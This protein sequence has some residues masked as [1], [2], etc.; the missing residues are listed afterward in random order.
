[1]LECQQKYDLFRTSIDSGQPSKE[2]QELFE[3][4]QW[5]VWYL[6]KAIER[7]DDVMQI[8]GP[9][10]YKMVK[11]F[12]ALEGSALELFPED[13]KDLAPVLES[14]LGDLAHVLGSP[15]EID[16]KKRELQPAFKIAT[17]HLVEFI[18]SHFT[19]EEMY[20]YARGMPL[21]SYF[22]QTLGYST[23]AAGCPRSRR[24]RDLGGGSN[25]RRP[26]SCVLDHSDL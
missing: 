26:S 24:V 16:F 13:Y 22:I 10:M 3:R 5:S 21:P 2:T 23:E 1:M 11:V 17:Q 8:F 7:L 6:R 15:S 25:N 19:V 12:E 4:W 14:P 18:K 9:E 20:H